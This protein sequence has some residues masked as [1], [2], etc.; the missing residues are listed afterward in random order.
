VFETSS[1]CSRT[2]DE[3]EDGNDR[4]ILLELVVALVLD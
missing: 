1:F 4:S 2:K 3:Q